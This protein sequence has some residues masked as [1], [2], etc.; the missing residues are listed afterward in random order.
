MIRIVLLALLFYFLYRFVVR[1]LLPV[2]RVTSAA[3]RQMQQMQQMQQEQKGESGGAKAPR[4]RAKAG[5]YID[6]E[7]VRS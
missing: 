2:L 3:R 4:E 6:F 1:F 7:E 5:E